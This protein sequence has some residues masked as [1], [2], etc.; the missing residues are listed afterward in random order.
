MERTLV[1]VKPDGLQRGL[2]G[3]IIVRFE[4]KGLKLIGLKMMRAG[5]ELLNDHYAH[6][7]DKPF[8]AGMKAFMQS[9]PL[10]AMAW[11]GAECVEAVRILTGV[12]DARKAGAGTIRGDLAMSMQNNLIHASDSV[13]NA[14]AEVT[15][16]FAPGELHEYDKSEYLHLY[17]QGEL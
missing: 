11:E 4:R 14:Q 2:V 1:L 10:V 13:E 7:A 15:R 5:D 8:F 9:S 6:H 17:G 12:T 3:E 16:F